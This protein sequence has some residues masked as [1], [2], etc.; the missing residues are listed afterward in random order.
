ML[1]VEDPAHL[2]SGSITHI[3]E[4]PVIVSSKKAKK[5]NGSTTD[6][7]TEVDHEAIKF[8]DKHLAAIA[9]PE[10]DENS[11]CSPSVQKV[12]VGSVIVV[13]IAV[14]WTG[15]TQFGKQTYSATFNAPYFTTW[16]S[17]SFMVVIYPVFIVPLICQKSPWRLRTF[18]RQSAMIFGPR[19]FCL[20]SLVIYLF[21]VIL[22]FCLLW[23]LTNYLYLHSLSKLFP[24]TV[25][26]VFSSGSC[27]V[28]ILSLLF[29]KE[30]LYLVR[31]LAVLLS[32]GGIIL[33]SYSEGFGASN[34][35]YIAFVVLAAF[36][37]ALYQV[38]FKLVLGNASG[39]KVA[40]F[41]TLVGCVNI[42]LLW[43]IVILLDYQNWEMIVWDDLPWTFLAGTASLGVLFNYLVNFGISYTYPLFISVGTLLG[44][45]FNAIAD[46]IFRG[47]DYGGWKIFSTLLIFC[48]FLFM[49]I[50]SDALDRYEKNLQCRG[51]VV[52]GCHVEANSDE[53]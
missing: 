35:I 43:P 12:I 42:L 2:H 24:G 44:V 31:S 26:A 16:F 27:F 53:T 33:M 28:Y 37:A 13:L 46:Y 48:G 29:L 10:N 11:C 45:P 23:L 8:I 30:K 1:Q 32:I 14:S 21:K 9:I 20:N 51:Q 4:Q 7:H 15:A 17:T 5:S 19:G 18:F 6:H 40:L 41:L 34:A 47:E 38:L 39:S 50:S 22:P 3:D 49:L 52:D 36:G 25:T